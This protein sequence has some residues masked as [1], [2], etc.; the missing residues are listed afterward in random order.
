MDEFKNK[1]TILEILHDMEDFAIMKQMQ[2][3]PIYLAG[4]S[5]C[6]LAD[7]IQ[8]GT[9]DIDIL[10]I[11]YAANIGRLFKLLGDYDILDL[12]LTTVAENF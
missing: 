4:G 10:D 3:K 9:I 7:V 12:E 1:K 5:A 8:R 2:C 11:N 6:I